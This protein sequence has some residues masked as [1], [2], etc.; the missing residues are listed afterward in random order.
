MRFEQVLMTPWYQSAAWQQMEQAI[1]KDRTPCALLG[2]SEGMKS[3]IIAALAVKRG[4]PM[5][6]VTPSDEAAARLAERCGGGYRPKG[7]YFFLPVRLPFIGWRR[8]PGK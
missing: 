7:A 8:C 1:D 2:L 4:Y 3:H 6:V 5:L